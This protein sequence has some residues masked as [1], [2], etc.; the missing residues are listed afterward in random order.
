M[1]EVLPRNIDHFFWDLQMQKIVPIISHP[2]RNLV[3]L[4]EPERL[5]KWTEM[6]ILSQVT[7]ASLMGDFGPMV[8]EFTVMLIEHHMAHII[9]TDSHGRGM[10]SPRLS[11]AFKK[12]ASIVGKETAYQMVCEIPR[13]IIQGNSISYPDPIPLK[14][15]NTGKSFWKRSFSF[16]QRAVQRR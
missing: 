1:T 14:S 9:A 10:R 6:G 8:Q 5:Y 16:F 12:A 13:Q 15:G 3:L 2:E 7:A 11:P 4:R